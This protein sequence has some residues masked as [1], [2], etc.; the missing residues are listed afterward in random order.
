[1]NYLV[2]IYIDQDKML[3]MM[4]D[5]YSIQG[6]TGSM[7]FFIY[8]YRDNEIIGVFDLGQIKGFYAVEHEN[9]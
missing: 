5:D 6:V 7:K 4:V 3:T 1:M 2:K 9:E 8:L